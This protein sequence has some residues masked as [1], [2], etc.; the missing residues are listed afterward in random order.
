MGAPG[1]AWQE[2][3]GVAV[4]VPPVRVAVNMAVNEMLIAAGAPML[5]PFIAVPRR[6]LASPRANAALASEASELA[7][8]SRP[9]ETSAIQTYD[10][11]A[12]S[13]SQEDIMGGIDA[14]ALSWEALADAERLEPR[15]WRCRVLAPNAR[16]DQ[17]HFVARRAEHSADQAPTQRVAPNRCRSF[18]SV[19]PLQTP[20]RPLKE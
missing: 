6:I 9:W 18:G 4:T 8:S 5:L 2:F 1:G 7:A 13:T 17:G 12:W 16:L 20:S 10:Y 19:P 3:V 11:A 15:G 14:T